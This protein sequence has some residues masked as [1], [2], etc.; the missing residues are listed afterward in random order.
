MDAFSVSLANAL[1]EA[2]M[3][4]SKGLAIAGTFSFFQFIMPL[5]GYAIVTLLVTAFS[6][7]N[8]FVP[9]VAL[10]VL[11]GLGIKMIVDGLSKKEEK[12]TVGVAAL[13][14]QGVATSLDALSVGLTISHYE[15][16]G[17][18]VCSLIIAAVTF[19]LCA[20]AVYLGKILKE[21]LSHRATVL[22]GAILI[23]IGIEIFIKGII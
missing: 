22:G 7:I 4:K 9:Y 23:I 12:P 5:I 2:E 18:L 15:F 6:V 19:A 13:L 14:V 21:K 11:S 20:L 10:A 8:K 17:A 1:G 3:K 16:I